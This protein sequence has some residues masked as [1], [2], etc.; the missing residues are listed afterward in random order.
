MQLVVIGN[1]CP[2]TVEEAIA[3]VPS[4][5]VIL[6]STPLLMFISV[7]VFL[8]LASCTSP[9]EMEKLYAHIYIDSFAYL[10]QLLVS[11]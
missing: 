9:T 7:S 1:L 6:S 3:M 4:L 11:I 5:K 2:E 8:I 10:K